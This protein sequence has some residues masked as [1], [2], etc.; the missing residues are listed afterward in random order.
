MP[1]GTNNGTH[2]D[3]SYKMSLMVLEVGVKLIQL[4]LQ[5]VVKL[6]QLKNGSA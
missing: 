1:K 3:V 5:L 4:L 2:D 6:P